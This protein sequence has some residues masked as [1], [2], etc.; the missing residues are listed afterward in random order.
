M[1]TSVGN[2]SRPMLSGQRFG[3]FILPRHACKPCKSAA[4]ASAIQVAPEDKWLART[5]KDVATPP[6]LV[7]L[8]EAS[9]GALATL[10][11]PTTRNE[12]YRFTDISPLLKTAVEPAAPGA[13]VTSELLQRTDLPDAAVVAVVVDGVLRS[14][15]CRGLADLPKGVYVG[16]LEGASAAV[17]EKLG[18]LSNSRGGP[19]AVLN[20]SLTPGVL[21]VAAEPGASLPGPV[22][23]LHVASASSAAAI[24][25]ANAPRLLVHAGVGSL[26][27][28]VEEYV[29]LE[30]STTASAAASASSDHGHYLTVS[31][32]ELFL[33][34]AAE[35]KHSYVQRE[36]AGSFHFKGTLVH[37][38]ERSR[39]TVTEASVGAAIARHD[40][41]ILQGGP[42]THTEMGHFLL[43]GPNQLHDLHSRLQLDHPHGTANQL[44]KCIVSHASGRGVF[45]G[46][47][48]VN[49][50]AQKTD[51]GQLSRNLLLVPLATVNVK[52]NLQ[53]I[54]DDVK[55]THGCAVS[56]L[57]DEE[58]F[59]FRARGISAEAARQ[60]LVF[61]FGSEVV[62]RMGRQALAKRVQEDVSRTL[63]SVEQFAG[64]A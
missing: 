3:L 46:N 44:H 26:V 41:T 49:R 29:G 2:M 16:P 51:A 1:Q 52:P 17:V 33:E 32:A 14:E 4:V 19:F 50:A 34:P 30:D 47:V 43:C 37:Q 22:F 20:G 59:Y 42:E 27:E 9:T 15:L 13:V 6:G 40:L 21:V 23:V 58:L 55:C 54:A 61:S 24:A 31:M 7:T 56:D 12:E 57:R 35:V 62:Q 48:K 28:V 45:D 64:A 18:S 8:R 60:A 63:R 39:Y 53:I 38:A 10:R 36:A 11:M 25:N 5:V